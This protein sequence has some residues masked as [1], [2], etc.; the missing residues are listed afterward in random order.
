MFILC[1]RSLLSV[2]NRFKFDILN[3]LR[4]S[5]SRRTEQVMAVIISGLLMSLHR[6]LEFM[7]HVGYIVNLPQEVIVVNV[8]DRVCGF[9]LLYILQTL[10]LH[11]VHRHSLRFNLETL[12]LNVNLTFAF[13]D[14][15]LACV[16]QRWQANRRFLV[17]A[18]RLCLLVHLWPRCVRHIPDIGP[19]RADVA[20]IK[21]LT[22]QVLSAL[23][24][25]D[26]VLL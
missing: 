26:S 11:L 3:W 15:V 5:F 8:I 7:V 10:L 4:P 22:I 25:R 14:Y 19:L 6:C 17:I 16:S 20:R 18:S 24:S 13:A 21:S 23:H 9:H 1:Q 12:W 2:I